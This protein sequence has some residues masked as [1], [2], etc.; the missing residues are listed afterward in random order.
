M[1]CDIRSKATYPLSLPPEATTMELSKITKFPPNPKQRRNLSQARRSQCTNQQYKPS[2]KT[3]TNHYRTLQSL[4]IRTRPSPHAPR[5]LPSRNNHLIR[6][7]RPSRHNLI[8]GDDSLLLQHRHSHPKSSDILQRAPAI[9][10]T[11]CITRLRPVSRPPTVPRTSNSDISKGFLERKYITR[12]H[13]EWR[14]AI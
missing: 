12:N 3:T 13:A 9:R 8:P 6:A 1:S 11:Q 10:N 14:R 5:T 7:P 4:N 2:L